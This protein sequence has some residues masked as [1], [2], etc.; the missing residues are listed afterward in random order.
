[1]AAPSAA[2]SHGSA[3]AVWTPRHLIIRVARR[4]R[5][6]SG[7]QNERGAPAVRRAACTGR[8]APRAVLRRTCLRALLRR[9]GDEHQ[10]ALLRPR[11]ASACAAPKAPSARS[12]RR[13]RRAP[14]RCATCSVR[15]AALQLQSV[16]LRVSLGESRRLTRALLR[17]P[18]RRDA[19]HRPH[20]HDV[21]RLQG[22][23]RDGG[24]RG[25]QDGDH[26][27]LLQRQG[28]PGC[29]SPTAYL[30][31]RP[32]LHIRAV[33][34]AARLGAVAMRR[35]AEALRRVASRCA[36]CGV[37]SQRGS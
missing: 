16:A 3:D 29:V 1:M 4:S 19:A 24:A 11:R 18:E 22:D 10:G 13:A 6:T 12:L 31:C 9:N 28:P 27:A 15:C 33:W 17:F 20:A 25:V 37:R 34:R 23:G 35:K 36:R 8:A 7:T 2:A 21:A 32:A 30:I 5:A 26:G 14:R